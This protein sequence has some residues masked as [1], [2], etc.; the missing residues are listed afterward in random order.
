MP[1]IKIHAPS[2]LLISIMGLIACSSAPN[3]QQVNTRAK[4]IHDEAQKL[5]SAGRPEEAVRMLQIL[6]DIHPDDPKIQAI[7]NQLTEEQRASIADSPW[8]GFNKSRRAKVESSIAAKIL[9]YIP[10]RLV[11]L[12]EIIE[13]EIGVG[14]GLCVG[15]WITRAAQVELCPFESHIAVGVGGPKKHYVWAGATNKSEV[16]LG[17]IGGSA[18]SYYKAGTGGLDISNRALWFHRP[19]HPLYQEY[20]DYWAIGV[21]ANFSIVLIPLY[22]RIE[23]HPIEVFDF[24]AGIVLWDP[25]GDD[26]ATTRRLVFDSNQKNMLKG[27]AHMLGDMNAEDK[28]KYRAQFPIL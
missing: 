2:I 23:I 13:V 21:E 3:L 14:P 26:L 22:L 10:D 9:W 25:L 1:G 5:L 24:L 6:S 16:V 17:P 8:L 4:E 20:R 18:V 11:D 15:A 7:I 28:E 27:M 19:S 12:W